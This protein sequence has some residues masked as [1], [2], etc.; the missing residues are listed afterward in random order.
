[1]IYFL[2]HGEDDESFIGGWSNVSL[3]SSGIEQI[4]E[5]SGF[6]KKII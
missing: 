3:T 5:A 4:R 6:I 1:M 2:R